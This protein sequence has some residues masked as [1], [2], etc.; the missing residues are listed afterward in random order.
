[1]NWDYP[2]IRA[3]VKELLER[4]GVFPPEAKLTV[5]D[6]T[7]NAILM[8]CSWR[9]ENDPE[10]PDRRATPIQIV[11]HGHVA[12]L[13]RNANADMV[14]RLDEALVRVVAR[15]MKRYRADHGLPYHRSPPPFEIRID[16]LDLD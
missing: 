12:D 13:F 5:Q 9:L 6:G 10:Q 2:M 16:T 7:G 1:M 4:S 11:V 8:S 15:R 14:K 3:H